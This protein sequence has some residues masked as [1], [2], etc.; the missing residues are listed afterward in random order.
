MTTCTER[1]RIDCSPE[2]AGAFLGDVQNLPSWTGFLRSVGRP[3]DDRFEVKTAMGTT[4]RTR[5]ERGDDRPVFDL[6]IGG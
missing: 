4:I 1:I 6:L 2:D 3:V 5:I